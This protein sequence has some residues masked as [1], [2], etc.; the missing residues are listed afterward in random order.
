MTLLTAQQPE[1]I[2]K[3]A[4]LTSFSLHIV[5]QRLG[6]GNWGE[7]NLL[8]CLVLGGTAKICSMEDSGDLTLT[9]TLILNFNPN[10]VP[11]HHLNPKPN[12]N[13]LPF[14]PNLNMHQRLI[15]AS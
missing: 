14:T 6:E 15:S 9:L 5:L 12:P 7:G 13:P 1:S 3:L 10:P 8:L 4:H 11:N 2:S